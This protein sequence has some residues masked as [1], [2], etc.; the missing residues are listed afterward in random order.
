MIGGSN[1]GACPVCRG[2]QGGREFCTSC[3]W[4]LEGEVF[5]GGP[6]PDDLRREEEALAAA[7]AE[8]DERAAALAAGDPGPAGEPGPAWDRLL[9]ELVEHPDAVLWFVELTDERVGLIRAEADR[10]GIPHTVDVGGAPWTALVP[11]FAEDPAD[12]A[13]QLAG[14]IG[15][16]PPVDRAALDDAVRRLLGTLLPHGRRHRTVLLTQ[17]PDWPLLARAAEAART[18]RS[19]DAQLGPV[20][21]G[22]AGVRLLLRGAPLHRDHSLVL[23]DVDAL[24]GAVR[25]EAKLLFPAGARLRPGETVT[26][27]VTVHGGV[28][29]DTLVTLP[30]VAAGSGTPHDAVST[31]GVRLP[32]LR[33]ADLTFVLHGPGEVEV[34]LPDGSAAEPVRDD[35]GTIIAA[36]PRRLARPPRLHLLLAV[37]LGYGASPDEVTARLDHARGLVT[38]LSGPEGA[39]T[40]VDVGLVGYYDHHVRESPY[41]PR[42]TLLDTLPLGPPAAAL[43]ALARWRP[44]RRR[45][46]TA[47]ALEDALQALRR[48]ATAPP[49][50]PPGRA[51][52]QRTVLVLG[53]R[54]PCEWAEHGQGPVPACPLGVD[55]RAELAGLREAG[56]R[57]LARRDGPADGRPAELALQPLWDHTELAWRTI[58]TDGTLP[59]GQAPAATALDLLPPWHVDGPP[60]RLALARS[61]L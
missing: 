37:E 15:T 6:T 10:N 47:S 28:D 56:V 50:A 42:G 48:L 32:A 53:A 20:S 29:A 2:P 13:F 34:L 49:W 46:D 43:A 61:L 41:A 54:P 25:P 59:P 31:H 19:P 21:G 44:Q 3:R 5:L 55:W 51:R 4:R 57:V 26:V 11:G 8:W 1:D 24:S 40:G 52:P 35:L 36:L 16:H 23:A 39:A 9:E 45:R 17:R 30:V 58:G 38:A 60:C 12:R 27:P 7:R 18:L 33:S 22:T 14:G